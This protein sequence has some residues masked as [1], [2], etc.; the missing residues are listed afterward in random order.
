MTIKCLFICITFFVPT[1]AYA[2]NDYYRCDRI[3]YSM[4]GVRAGV[5]PDDLWFPELV[6]IIADD[7]K[8]LAS[9]YGQDLSRSKNEQ[10]FNI[11]RFKN[12]FSINGQNLASSGEV[13]LNFQEGGKK[14]AG[15]AK[16]KCDKPIKTSW[17]PEE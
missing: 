1:Y 12:G 16:Y 7:K 5:K 2:A 15:G 11:A 6:F 4:F 14:T 10:K 13:K 8:W 3:S 17:A 9:N